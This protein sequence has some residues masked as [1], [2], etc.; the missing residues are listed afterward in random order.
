MGLGWQELMLCFCVLLPL[1]VNVALGVWVY[2]D[3]E[4]RGESGALWTLIVLLTSVVGL[5]VWLIVRSSKPRR[6]S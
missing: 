3:A 5:L 1:A 2:R 6:F 4:S